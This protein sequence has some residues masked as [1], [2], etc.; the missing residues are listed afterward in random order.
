[1]SNFPQSALGVWLS[2]VPQTDYLTPTPNE[3]NAFIRE[4]IK[5]PDLPNLQGSEKD[6]ADYATGYAFATDS[7]N[8]SWTLPLAWQMDLASQNIGRYLLAAMGRVTTTQPD[9]ANAPNVYD[10]LF[11]PLDLA[12]TVVMPAY[13]AGYQLAPAQGGIDKKIPSLVAKSLKMAASGLAKLDGNV[14]WEGSGEEIETSGTVVGTHVQEIQGAMNYF[15]SKQSE[16]IQTDLDGTNPVNHKC[17]LKSW[18]FGVENEFAENDWGCPRSL[19][20]NTELGAL[21]SH[22][23]L[24]RQKFMIDWLMKMRANSPEHI[25]MKNRT[26]L[27]VIAKMIGGVIEGAFKHTLEITNHLVKY[28]TKEDTFEDGF[29]HVKIT[30]KSLFNVSENKIVQVKLRNNVP[31]YLV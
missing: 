31:S 11:E 17:E 10:H 2:R 13:S 12:T 4:E 26:P 24:I 19:D 1:M 7:W 30:P 27:K 15:F 22:Y 16:L 20:D 23:L 21:R 9:A 18:N 5:N 8:E 14:Q 6:N 25:A 3:A 29:A 28:T